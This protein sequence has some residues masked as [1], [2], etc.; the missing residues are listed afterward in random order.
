MAPGTRDPPASD[1]PAQVCVRCSKPIRPGTASQFAGRAVHM[2]CL[3]QATQLDAVEQQDWASRNRARAEALIEQASELAARARAR[4]WI[5]PVC[6]RALSEGGG[7][8]FQ[9]DVLVHAL[10]WRAAP[11]PVDDPPPAE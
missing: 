10:C 4:P 11:T 6:E 9:G 5:C 2:R 7:L 1:P 8:L 3:A